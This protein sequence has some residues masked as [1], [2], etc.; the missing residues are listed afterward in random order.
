MDVMH[1]VGNR[2]QFIKLAPV[3]RELRGRKIEEGIIHTGQH[4]DTDMS[5]IFFEELKIPKP[6]RNLNV[7]SGSHAQV[8][9]KAM[10]RIEETLF[11]YQPKCVIVY[12]DTNSTLAAALAAAKLCIPIV[13]VEAGLRIFEK[14]NP[15]E[16]N[17]IVVDHIADYLCTPDKICVDNLLKEGISKKKIF[18]TG[19]VMYD[20]FLYCLNNSTIPEGH[21]R[22]PDDY[23]LMTWHRQENTCSK[24]KME[25][26]INFVEQIHYTVV[27]PLHPRT[28]KLL[29][30]YGLEERINKISFLKIIHPV[31]YKEMVSL[32]SRCRLLIS[33]SGGASK[34]ASFVGKKCIYI[35]NFD[36]WKELIQAGYIQSV[37]MNNEKS[38]EEALKEIENILIHGSKLG[39]TDV[40]GDGTAAVKIADIITGILGGNENEKK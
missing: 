38:V 30:Q 1:I 22:C 19:D 15:E 28:S 6:V 40:F 5:D 34:E 4:Y 37:D 23:I 14:R 17:R 13:H 12:G 39:R 8:T 18:F 27:L 9:G 26:I 32:L 36:V 25:Q 21:S 31:S 10:I 16:C 33:D 24:E 7:G 20:Q 2:P 3:S 11:E 35:L 29:S